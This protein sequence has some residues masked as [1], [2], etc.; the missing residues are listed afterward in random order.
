MDYEEIK[1][2]LEGL[3]ANYLNNE[4]L[5]PCH[6]DPVPE[7][8]LTSPSGTSYLIDWEYSGMNSIYWDIAAYILESQLPEKSI[9]YLL[10]TYFNRHITNNELF[11]IKIYILAQ[12]LLDNLGSGTALQRR[13]FL[14]LLCFPIRTPKTEY[15]T[16]K[17]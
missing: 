7:N 6:N 8:F 9:Y 4:N 16:I 1:R 12:D 14:R 13:R 10:E 11:K 3:Y 15:T 5:V 2:Y 17:I